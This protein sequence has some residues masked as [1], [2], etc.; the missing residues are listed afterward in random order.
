[1]TRLPPHLLRLMD[2]AANRAREA[3]RCLED[4]ARFVL[5]DRETSA[6]LKSIRH[7]L[8][9]TLKPLGLSMAVACRD[10]DGD[11][12]K[13]IKQPSQFELQSMA[14]IADA[15][16]GRASEA[17]RS[18]EE[19]A[20]TIDISAATALESL[21]YRLYGAAKVVQMATQQV[22][23]LPS[24]MLCVLITESLC[25]G[26]WVQTLD[27]VL[28]GGADMVQLREKQMEDR[29]LLRRGKILSERCSKA[30]CV[31]IINDRVQV[32]L[33]CGA[34]VHVGQADL[35]CAVLRQMVP[36][37]MIIGVSTSRMEEAQQAV[38][39]GASYIGI[40]PIFASSTKAKPHLAGVSYV[41]QIADEQMSIP[42]L[43]ISGITLDNIVHVVAAGVRAVAVS[44]A[45]IGAED[46]SA[47]CR[48]FK[49]ALL[50]GAP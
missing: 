18:L 29:E 47:V 49:A 8:I 20:K 50:A 48:S 28:A 41:R 19:V 33:A 11:V 4:I 31:P 17:L 1:M 39:D 26:D 14:A 46:P 6:T 5:S 21:R 24:V 2:A 7:D 45:V 32:A 22:G 37:D 36:P 35:P 13:A 42:A 27:A 10:I 38:R 3:V 16:F 44:S 25:R 43:A 12:G 23:R 9:A 34:G 40:G 30:G 15:A